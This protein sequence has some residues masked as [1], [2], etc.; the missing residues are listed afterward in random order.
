MTVPLVLSLSIADTSPPS[1][2]A[3]QS[4]T[5]EIVPQSAIDKTKQIFAETWEP[6]KYTEHGALKST[7][8]PEKSLRNLGDQLNAQEIEM[9]NRLEVAEE[10]GLTIYDYKAEFADLYANAFA[11][12]SDAIPMQEYLER[13]EEFM[14]RYGVD[15]ATAENVG[16]LELDVP[17]G[18][19]IVSLEE[20]NAE[21]QQAVKRALMDYVS[22]I[23]NM[24]VELVQYMG[25]K[26]I[27]LIELPAEAKYDG[28]AETNKPE[29]GIIYADPSHG[30]NGLIAHESLHLWDAKEC[31]PGGMF[32]DPQYAELNPDDIYENHDGYYSFHNLGISPRVNDLRDQLRNGSEEEKAEA[33]RE[34]DELYS[35][36][37]VARDYGFTNIAEDKA[38][39]GES[40]LNGTARGDVESN[41]SPVYQA[42][43][44]FLLARIGQD[45]PLYVEYVAR[46]S[47]PS[48]Y[49][50]NP[51]DPSNV[52][53]QFLSSPFTAK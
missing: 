13:V 17:Q 49:S 51:L 2:E 33:K 44:I 39:F 25:L 53:D 24:P 14:D 23:G 20:L 45:L 41:G 30:A 21:D 40:I 36:V 9:N 7:N 27:V 47:T 22:S 5:C 28:F 46:T 37:V 18:G 26:R 52:P 15:I 8:P 19:H 48:I 12:N 6:H 11:E 29:L 3:L 35:S 10:L 34:L 4:D 32:I 31:G 16:G 38:T 1:L 50:E 43:A 42:K